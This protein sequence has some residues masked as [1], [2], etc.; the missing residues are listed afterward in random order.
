MAA[1]GSSCLRWASRTAWP[2]AMALVVVPWM[3]HFFTSAPLRGALQVEAIEPYSTQIL[4]LTLSIHFQVGTF[5]TTALDPDSL[6]PTNADEKYFVL[7]N[8]LVGLAIFFSLFAFW[9]AAKV[10][11]QK[12]TGLISRL[13]ASLVAL[14]C[15]FLSWFSIHWN[16][17]GA[18]H[19]Y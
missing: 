4:R 18:A 11:H 14:S 1:I 19:R 13:K 10:L 3:P 7:F 15:A 8:L 6:P 9:A 2:M 12:E 16:L 5:S 17:I